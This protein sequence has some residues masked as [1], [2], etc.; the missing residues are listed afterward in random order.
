[1]GSARVIQEKQ[2]KDNIAIRRAGGGAGGKG[3]KTLALR[4]VRFLC[5]MGGWIEDDETP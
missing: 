2:K 5:G 3:R 1:M 4:M